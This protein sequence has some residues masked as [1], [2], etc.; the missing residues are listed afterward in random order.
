[1]DAGVSTWE[2]RMA[3]RARV[4]R[5][6]IPGRSVQQPIP[7]WQDPPD[8]GTCTECFEWR[9]YPPGQ[10]HFGFA[11]WRTC[12]GCDHKHHEDEVWLAAAT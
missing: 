1:M 4:R 5:P 6:N 9:R 2:E 12:H 8:D 10:E 7:P 11:W 3:Q